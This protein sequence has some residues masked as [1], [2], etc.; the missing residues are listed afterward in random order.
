MASLPQNIAFEQAK[1]EIANIINYCITKLQLPTF[2]I[3]VILSNFYNE[4]HSQAETEFRNAVT[5][6]NAQIEAEKEQEQE[7]EKSEI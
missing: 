6:Y 2:M 5:Q 3:E 7:K 4:I 1:Q